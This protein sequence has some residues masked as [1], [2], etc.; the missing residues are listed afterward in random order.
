VGGGEGMPGN[1]DPFQNGSGLKSRR[2][3]GHFEFLRVVPSHWLLE[4]VADVGANA[5]QRPA[6]PCRGGRGNDEQNSGALVSFLNRRSAVS[7]RF[8]RLR[9]LCVNPSLRFQ[10]V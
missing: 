1:F 9:Y 10:L 5:D 2:N 4:R 6:S 8:E 3:R 7:A